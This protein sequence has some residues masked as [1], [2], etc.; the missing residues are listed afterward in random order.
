[1]VTKIDSMDRAALAKAVLEG[2][3]IDFPGRSKWEQKLYAAKLVYVSE[4]HELIQRAK[5]FTASAKSLQG[6]K[7]PDDPRVKNLTMKFE[8]I[9]RDGVRADAS[10]QPHRLERRRLPGE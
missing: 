10:L 4:G 6:N 9:V 1:M 5:Q 8:E 3:D 2:V 7:N